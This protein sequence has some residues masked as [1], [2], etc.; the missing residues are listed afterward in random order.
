MSIREREIYSSPNGDRWSLAR[1]TESGHVFVRHRPN[2]PSG[3]QTR[4]MEVGEFLMEGG[5]GPEKQEL[6][7]QIGS[8]VEDEPEGSSEA[9]VFYP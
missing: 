5:S 8:M 6:L 7:R 4:D 9:V 1:D 3:G 2:I